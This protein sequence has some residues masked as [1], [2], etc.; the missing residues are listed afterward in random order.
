MVNWKENNY[1]FKKFTEELA[2]EWINCGFNKKE[3][4]EWLES[5]L[6]SNDAEFAKWLR[7]ELKINSE[8]F[9]E[10]YDEQELRNQ[11]QDFLEGNQKK[12]M[13][14]WKRMRYDF[15][16][17][18]QQILEMIGLDHEK[19]KKLIDGDLVTD[20]FYK[21][22]DS[23]REILIKLSRNV[24]AEEEFI[25]LME[26]AEEMQ[27]KI[28]KSIKKEDGI[29][30]D[31]GLCE[32][33]KKPNTGGSVDNPNAS[34]QYSGSHNDEK[35]EYYDVWCQPCNSQHFSQDFDKW[36]SGN[37]VIDQFIQKFQLE[38]NN[39]RQVLEWIPYE[40]FVNV[41]FL[42]EG[43]FGKVYKAVWTDRSISGWDI[44]KN[45]WRRKGDGNRQ[46][47]GNLVALKVLNNS[48]NITDEFL[49]EI[50]HHKMLSDHSNI[51]NCYGISQDPQTKN[52]IMV[53]NYQEGGNLRQYLKNNKLNLKDKFWQL[54]CIT[55]GLGD[56]HKKG[57]MHRDFH[58]GNIL[59]RGFSYQGLFKGGSSDSLI[60][61]TDLGLSKPVS[62]KDSNKIY[63]V[64]PYVAPEVLRGGEYTQASDI[65]SW[66]MVAYDLLYEHAP[67][68]NLNYDDFLARKICQGLRPNLNE[69]PLP[70]LFKDLINKCWNADPLQRPTTDELY[71]ILYDLY[72]ADIDDK[73]GEIFLQRYKSME[74]TKKNIKMSKSLEKTYNKI[75][76]RAEFYQQ[77]KEWEEVHDKKRK[78]IEREGKVY[79][80][81]I[82]TSRPLDFKNLPK[83]QNSKEINE[84][85][86]VSKSMEINIDELDSCLKECEKETS[87]NQKDWQNINSNFSEELIRFWQSHNFTSQQCRE[88][89]NIG[90]Q[91]TD[92]RF[93]SWLHNT[94]NLTPEQVLN[95]YNLEQLRTEYNQFQTQIEQ[96]PK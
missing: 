51:V 35:K 80:S 95:H 71:N 84:Q 33:C 81:T 22:I 45:K 28:V 36:T 93:A 92:H 2:Q 17:E 57:I 49:Q 53:M 27:K 61:I 10:N 76:N 43:G 65:Y 44:K 31:Y 83:L 75:K 87:D 91:P 55:R 37:Y 94:K 48:Q 9:L 63:G 24:N 82:C 52:Y 73:M 88:W 13:N 85:F 40:K 11:Y 69:M 68:H 56:I 32:V 26:K 62:E 67:Y 70:R 41:E 6:K 66:G 50:S 34:S 78:E 46:I 14:K 89:L 5:G 77:Y 38:A 59:N 72:S 90:L 19:F 47:V 39:D 25:E 79:L 16:P 60:F 30:P 64:L 58:P 54:R 21:Y 29:I 86:W 8:Q 3:T 1:P 4:R 74:I 96:P 42:A 18:L 15:T 7:N 12:V 20:D 23:F